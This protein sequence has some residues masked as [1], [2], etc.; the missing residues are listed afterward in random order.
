MQFASGADVINTV[1]GLGYFA[2]AAWRAWENRR[3]SWTSGSWL[4]LGFVVLAGAALV[5]SGFAITVAFDNHEAWVG[6]PGSNLRGGWVLV[7]MGS[8]IGGLA[9][10]AAALAWAAIGE[11]ERQFPFIGSRIG[12]L[13][14]GALPEALPLP[15]ADVRSPA[16]RP[17]EKKDGALI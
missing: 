9:L 3:D 12:T 10:A 15:S 7:T 1:V 4:G 14:G 2:T 11:P 16:I 5:G 13:P 6:T 8:T 17:R